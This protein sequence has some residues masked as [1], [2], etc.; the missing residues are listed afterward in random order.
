VKVAIGCG[1]R[2]TTRKTP[3]KCK[4]YKTRYC[5]YFANNIEIFHKFHHIVDNSIVRHSGTLETPQNNKRSRKY[6]D[7]QLKTTCN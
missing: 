5:N 2:H 3:Q 7:F 4:I 1:I 6:L